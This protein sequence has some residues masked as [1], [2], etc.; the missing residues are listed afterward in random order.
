MPSEVENARRTGLGDKGI[1]ESRCGGTGALLA[2]WTA[3]HSEWRASLKTGTDETVKVKVVS[4]NV[5]VERDMADSR[6]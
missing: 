1:Y 2:N 4:R 6:V 5:R 3:S